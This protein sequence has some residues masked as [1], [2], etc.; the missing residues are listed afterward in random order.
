MDDGGF[1]TAG[2]FG[3]PEWAA[4]ADLGLFGGALTFYLWAFALERTTPTRVASTIT[5]NPV[6]ASMVAALVLGEPIGLHLLVGI[7]AV[8]AGIWL[9]S[10]SPHPTA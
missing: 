2:R 7:T 6:T 3:L 1:A 9:A 4:I 5:V 8:G 10:T